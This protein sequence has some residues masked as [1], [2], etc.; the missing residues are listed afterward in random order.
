MDN[1]KIKSI[2]EALLFINERPIEIT[3]LLQVLEIGRK[4]IEAAFDELSLEYQKRN[5]GICII[6]VAGG[7]QMCSSPKNETWVKKMYQERTKQKLST[8]ALETLAVIA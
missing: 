8:A 6:K 4:E 5:S 1:E 7:Y 2:L 3:E